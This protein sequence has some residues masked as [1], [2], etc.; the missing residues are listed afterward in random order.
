M[1]ENN[2]FFNTFFHGF[3][4]HI[5]DKV[6]SLNYRILRRIKLLLSNSFSNVS[7]NKE[8]PLV[9]TRQGD[10]NLGNQRAPARFQR[11]WFYYACCAQNGYS[12]NN[13]QLCIHCFLSDFF[14][15][16]RSNCYFNASTSGQYFFDGLGY[17][18]SWHWVNR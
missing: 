4:K 6:A 12:A 9:A 13:T 17:H 5:T 7:R 11:Q 1:T 15:F 10:I 8:Y 2:D 16:R 3:I 18:A 14:S